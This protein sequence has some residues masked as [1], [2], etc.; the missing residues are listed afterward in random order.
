MIRLLVEKLRALDEAERTRLADRAVLL[1]AAEAGYFFA[2]EIRRYGV[3][4]ALDVLSRHAS[5]ILGRRVDDEDLRRILD[6]NGAAWH[7]FF[8]L[9]WAGRSTRSRP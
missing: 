1:S 9:A 4:V 8:D 7:Y 6:D 5:D 2:A 3:G